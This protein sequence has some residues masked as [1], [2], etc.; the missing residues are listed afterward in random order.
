MKR[1]LPPFGLFAVL[2]LAS[3]PLFAL[4]PDHPTLLREGDRVGVLRMPERYAQ[5]SNTILIDH[6]RHSLRDELRGAGFDAFETGATYDDLHRQDEQNANYYIEIVSAD[7]L[8]EQKGN[9]G[10]DVDR[11]GVEMAMVVSRVAAAVRVYDGRTLELLRTYEL[12]HSSRAIVPT[13]IGVGYRHLYAAVAVPL[14]HL[15]Q[16]RAAA[17]DVA[18]DAV[19]QIRKAE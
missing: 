1:L 7:A 14:I 10:F 2:L 11:V 18:R 8:A 17:H 6:V 9:V 12:H 19:Q 3:V 15:M 13:D 16:Y 5:G 4:S